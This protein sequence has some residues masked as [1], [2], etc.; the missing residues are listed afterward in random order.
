[1]RRRR[2]LVLLAAA[3]IA[4]M[5]GALVVQYARTYALA[6]QAAQLDQRQ[7]DLAMDNQALRDEIQRLQTDD[8]YIEWLARTELG[9]VR[10]GEVE[11]LAVPPKG[12]SPE[13]PDRDAASAAAAPAPAVHPS[14]GTP[15]DGGWFGR[16]LARVSWLLSRLHP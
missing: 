11:F 7:R 3:V 10:P 5:V 15:A 2:A 16:L 6:R 9:L 4:W 8:A 12:A 1:V 14:Q 13:R